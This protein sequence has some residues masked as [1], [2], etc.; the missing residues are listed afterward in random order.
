MTA[1]TTAP[2]VSSAP[3][4]TRKRILT[5][6][7]PTGRL[8]LGHYVGTLENRVKLQDAYDTFLLVADY[9][10]LTT[11]LDHLDEI[12]QNVRDVVLDNLSTGFATALPA[13]MLP[14]VG[15]VGDQTLVAE[16]IDDYDVEAII[17]FA[18]N[19][20]RKYGPF[21]LMFIKRSKLASAASRISARTSGATPA[22]LTSTSR[23]P[24]FSRTN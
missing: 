11:R 21:T 4:K 10:M 18:A 3:K 7:R 22:L 9:H 19:C 5:G 15:D 23:R 17:H 24:N 2:T 20:V 12:G 6:D 13:S 16:L 14:I 8:H 1:E